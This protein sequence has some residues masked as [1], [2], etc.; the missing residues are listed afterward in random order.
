MTRDELVRSQSLDLPEMIRRRKDCGDLAGALRALEALLRKDGLPRMLRAR[1]TVEKERIRRL[2]TQYPL[3]REA[4]F[5]KLKE[6]VPSLT[7]EEF[8]AFEDQGFFDWI[9]LEGEKRYFVRNTQLALKRPEIAKR[10]D[11]PLSP[12][13]EWLDPLIREARETGVCAR[14]MEAEAVMNLEETAFRPGTYRAWIPVPIPCAQQKDIEILSP[15]PDRLSPPEA[16]AGCAYWERT[17]E[18]K[19]EPFRIRYAWTGEI[20]Y[21]DPLHAPAPEK[22][23]YPGAGPV[24]EADLS[25]DPPFIRFTPFLRSLSEE[26][27]EEGDTPVQKAW[28]YY[29]FITEKVRYSYVRDYFQIDGIGEF[30]ARELKGD[31][32]LQALLFISLC[33]IGGIPARWQSGLCIDEDGVGA[34]DWAQF[35]LPGWGWLFADPSFGGSAFRSGALSRRDFYFGN[36]DPTRLAAN[37]VFEAELTP[38]GEMLRI[39]PYDNQSGELERVGAELPFTGR[40]LDT[41]F[42]L[43]SLQRI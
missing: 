39:D 13:S 14:R 42:T 27:T 28:K 1:L 9:M 37:R 36:L 35:H 32:G 21:A 29:A 3:T 40:E 19:W 18:K 16:E 41:D 8:E 12:E 31:C 2:P 23:L 6:H 34:H 11:R 43:I 33:R 15:R 22:P 30:C 5:G 24:C 17:M 26:L 25:E 20:R 38:A 4:A 7:E 10:S